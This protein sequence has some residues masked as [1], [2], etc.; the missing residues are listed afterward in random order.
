VHGLVGSIEQLTPTA[1][2]RG[3]K[4]RTATKKK[5]RGRDGMNGTK[6]I[7]QRGINAENRF[8]DSVKEQ[9]KFSKFEA[10]KILE[11]FKK[12]KAVRIDAVTGQFNLTNGAFWD[13]GVM[14]DAIT[15]FDNH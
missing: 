6:Q 1:P 3:L 14:T 5:R 13:K 12:I 8:I 7:A 2:A 10:E 15:F 11:T 4:R 9:F